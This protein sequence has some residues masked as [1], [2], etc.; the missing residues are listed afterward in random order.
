MIPVVPPKSNRR[1]PWEYDRELY[2]KRNQVERLFPR[3]KGFRRIFS[4]ALRNSTWSSRSSSISVSSSR[5]RDRLSRFEQW[6]TVTLTS[7]MFRPYPI[8]VSL[9]IRLPSVSESNVDPYP[10]TVNI[11]AVIQEFW[12]RQ[13][14][15]RNVHV[16]YPCLKR[17]ATSKVVPYAT[18]KV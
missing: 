2:K 10:R 11:N 15:I 12:L 8:C 7:R 9:G 16:V 17:I 14:E 5:L 3:L 18:A 13:I 6:L 1:K 4:R